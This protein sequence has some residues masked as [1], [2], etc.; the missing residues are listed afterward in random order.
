MA[1]FEDLAFDWS[2]LCQECPE[3]W[4]ASVTE[5]WVEG[6]NVIRCGPKVGAPWSAARGW[7]DES[8]SRDHCG[9]GQV[10]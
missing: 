5:P 7:C 6:C 10:K 1:S 9:P 8:M 4:T 3:C 2:T